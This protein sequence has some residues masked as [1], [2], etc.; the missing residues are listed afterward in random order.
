MFTVKG[1]CKAAQFKG[2]TKNG[3]GQ[4]S[5]AHIRYQIEVVDVQETGEKFFS[6]Y[7]I[8]IDPSWKDCLTQVGKEVVMQ[9][10]IF[11]QEFGKFI[12]QVPSFYQRPVV[13]ADMPDMKKA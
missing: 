2:T 1:L 11:G 5:M 7:D 6:I 3:N 4:T 13:R 12:L 9:V 10:K 8:K